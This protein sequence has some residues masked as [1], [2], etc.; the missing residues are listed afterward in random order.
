M[1]GSSGL[2]QAGGSPE[3]H[4][5]EVEEHRHHEHHHHE[6][7]E[8]GGGVSEHSPDR[9]HCRPQATLFWFAP[10]T[11]RKPAIRHHGKNLD[12]SDVNTPAF[13]L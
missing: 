11:P 13:T 6:V 5:H 3:H 2:T 9:A 7:E 4:H 12:A 1:L 10:Q 8:D